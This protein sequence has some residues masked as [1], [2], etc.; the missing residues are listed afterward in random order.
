MF[1][2][3]RSRRGLTDDRTDATIIL[4]RPG[5]KQYPERVQSILA[6]L[7]QHD[8]HHRGQIHA[9][10]TGTDVAPPQLDEFFRAQ[11]ASSRADDLRA[12]GIAES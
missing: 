8:V 9:M 5:D 2:T 7:F 1:S 12:L 11:D 4:S 6:H 3:A 10:L